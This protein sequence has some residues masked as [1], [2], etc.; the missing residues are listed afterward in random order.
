[1]DRIINEINSES[2]FMKIG[3]AGSADWKESG[4][5]YDYYNVPVKNEEDQL[6]GFLY[7]TNSGD[8]IHNMIHR[9][10]L[11][12]GGFAEILDQ[13]GKGDRRGGRY[14]GPGKSQGSNPQGKS[15]TIYHGITGQ[16]AA[17]GRFDSFGN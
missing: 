11:A 13:N 1:M 2:R 6:V 14:E 9:T 4:G 17:N 10:V 5:Y 16:P 12:E 15:E 7:A 8:M 3:L